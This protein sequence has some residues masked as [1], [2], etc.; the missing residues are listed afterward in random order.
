MGGGEN[1]ALRL[2]LAQRA[3]GH[4]VMAIGLHPNGPLREQFHHQ[5]VQV[6]IV[7]K[8]PGFDLALFARLRAFVREA[9]LDVVHTHNPQALVYAAPAARTAGAIV[10]HTKHGEGHDAT[11]RMWM[12]RAAALSVHAFV[13]VSAQT[14]DYAKKNWEAPPGKIDVIENGVDLTRFQPDAQA[15]QRVRQELGLPPGA[16]LVGTVGRLEPVKNHGLLIEACAPLLGPNV[17][18]VIVGEGPAATAL[19]QQIHALKLEGLVH[20]LGL[21]T[22]VPQLLAGFDIFAL[23]SKTEGLPLVLI[24]AMA[25]SLPVVSTSVGGIPG[26]V[27]PGRTGVLV[28]NHDAVSLRSGLQRLVSDQEQRLGMGQAGRE[29]VQE[30]Y[31]LAAMQKRYADLYQELATMRTLRTGR[32]PQRV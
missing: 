12:R 4:D 32:L 27:I 23:S 17:H 31:S 20:L 25:A 9:A 24:E 3:A 16:L 19:Q 11:R 26:V 18:L 8:A 30:H 1:V 13:A 5:G 10:I 28:P 14:R 7:P 6:R 2:A 15:Y 21:R 29:R 22:D